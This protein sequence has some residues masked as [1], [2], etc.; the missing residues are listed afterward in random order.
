MVVG[1]GLLED[2]E[3]DGAL[4]GDEV[5]EVLDGGVRRLGRRHRPLAQQRR[6]VQQARNRVGAARRRKVAHL[7]RRRRKTGQRLPL[8]LTEFY[9]V[10]TSM[11]RQLSKVGFELDRT[12]AELDQVFIVWMMMPFC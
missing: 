11:E 9:W 10:F 1:Q 6:L 5:A 4:G 8:G 3:Q 7:P 12:L 2:A